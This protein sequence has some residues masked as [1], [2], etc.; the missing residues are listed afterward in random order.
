MS[1]RAMM[2]MARRNPVRS[3]MLWIVGLAVGGVALVGGIAYAA[4]GS[5]PG[6]SPT[7]SPPNTLPTLLK[8]GERYKVVLVVPAAIPVGAYG[9]Q[10]GAQSALNQI[11]PGQFKVSQ[12]TVVG[13]TV[14]MLVDVVGPDYTVPASVTTQLAGLTSAGITFQATDM[15]ATPSGAG[16]PDI[17]V[18]GPYNPTTQMVSGE[19][20][21][22]SMPPIAG[23]S[24][25]STV[26][27][28]TTSSAQGTS[29]YTVSQSWDVNQVPAS[30]PSQDSNANEWRFVITLTGAGPQSPTGFHIFTTGGAA[31]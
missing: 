24:L 2:T 8:Q 17:L 1:K 31:A 14:T 15:G 25:A 28:L 21:L 11:A 16:V 13:G 10:A 19:T 27:N 22:V 18:A 5:S 7:P 26:Q 3:R 4:T 6:P 9:T 12:I 30:W 20:Y 29:Q 23:Q